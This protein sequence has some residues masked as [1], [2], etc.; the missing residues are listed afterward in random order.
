MKT[1]PFYSI[2]LLFAL[3]CKKDNNHANVNATD[4]FPNKVGDTWL[5]LVN[6]TTVHVF[7]GNDTT[8]AQYN[9]DISVIDS[10]QLAG[11]IKANVWVYNYPGGTDTNYVFQNGDTIRF[12]ANTRSYINI[13]RQYII[14][15]SLHNSW[16]Y[17]PDFSGFTSVTV[18]SQSNI[19]VGQNHFDNAFHIYGDAGMPDAG[20]VIDEWLENNVGVVKRYLHEGGISGVNHFTTWS[21]VSYHLK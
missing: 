4:I 15:L 21:L 11:G 1:I 6:D 14:P 3:G 2:I 19:I 12:A 20:F 13:V 18:D 17:V 10:V 5:Y 8:I 7:N 9:L 16:Q